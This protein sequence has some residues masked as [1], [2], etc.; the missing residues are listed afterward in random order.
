MI[1][2]ISRLD[3]HKIMTQKPDRSKKDL[4]K[5]REEEKEREEYEREYNIAMQRSQR[6]FYNYFTVFNTVL[7]IG[8][9]VLLFAPI[10]Y[11]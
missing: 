6:K 7:F 11:G 8:W 4:I 3:V 9:N 1:K 5:L 2:D 10:S